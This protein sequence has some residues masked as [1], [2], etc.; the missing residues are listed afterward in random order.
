MITV[1][2]AADPTLGVL[3]NV[4]AYPEP[5]VDGSYVNL[6]LGV[7]DVPGNRRIDYDAAGPLELILDDCQPDPA[8]DGTVYQSDCVAGTA[9]FDAPYV[10]ANGG[11]PLELERGP[12]LGPAGPQGTG[13]QPYAVAL[14]LDQSRRIQE[15]DPNDVRLGHLR[16]FLSSMGDGNRAALTAFAADEAG[17]DL[18]LLP[19]Q[20]VTFYPL[21]SPGLII[22]DEALLSTVDSLGSLEGGATP[23]FESFAQVR[24]YLADDDSVPVGTQRWIVVLADGHDDTCGE[25]ADCLAELQSAAGGI[26][27]GGVNVLTIGLQSGADDGDQLD[28][29]RLTEY[30]GYSLWVTNPNQLGIVFDRLGSVLDGTAAPLVALFRLESP[31]PG[32]FQSGRIVRGRLRF[33]DCPFGC[34]VMEFPISVQIP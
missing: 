26:P 10:V 24:Q 18:S 16:Y 30:S 3:V 2:P 12:P 32:A 34:T 20:P 4:N 28:L 8:N 7:L 22:P 9:A 11:R 17:G 15:A 29:S 25:R 6:Y 21:Q 23:L 27:G 5:S 33:E 14:L 1:R 31:T 19:E 13:P